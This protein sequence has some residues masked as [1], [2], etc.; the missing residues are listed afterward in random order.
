MASISVEF[1][2]S[3]CYADS[4]FGRARWHAA[5]ER[6]RNISFKPGNLPSL[7]R[8]G[9]AIS[10]QV[11]MGL[12]SRVIFR[13]GK[14]PNFLVNIARAPLGLEIALALSRYQAVGEFNRATR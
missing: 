13:N 12:V 10:S 6:L 1:V 14:F 7:F 4:S 11:E 3:E 8:T 5:L 2:L 9:R